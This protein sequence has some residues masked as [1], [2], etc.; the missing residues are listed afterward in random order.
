LAGV[1]WRQ[2]DDHEDA[3]D[4]IGRALVQ[5]ATR[6]ATK[7]SIRHSMRWFAHSRARPHASVFNMN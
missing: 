6:G 5:R 2:D 4:G 3:T 1:S 7:A